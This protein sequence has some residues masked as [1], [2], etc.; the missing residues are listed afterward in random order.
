[1]AGGDFEEGDLTNAGN[2]DM[3]MEG[4]EGGTSEALGDSMDV[5]D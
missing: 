2:M 1:M 3:S 4:T 5:D